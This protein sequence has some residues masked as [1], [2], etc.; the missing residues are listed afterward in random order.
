MSAKRPHIVVVGSLNVDHT[1]R[2]PHLPM[3]GETLTASSAFTCFGGKGANQALAAARA[4]AE[5][6]LVGAVG[7]DDYGARYLEHLQ[8]E[9]IDT[10]CLRVST[11]PTGAAFIAVDDRGE[12]TILVHPGANH[13]LLPEHLM[14]HA[15][16][17]READALLLQLECPL[18][19]VQQAVAQARVA[20][21]RVV[22]NPSPWSKAFLEAGMEVD[23][24]IVNETEAGHLLGQD[25]ERALQQTEVALMRARCQT[26]VI[27]RGARSTLALSAVEGLVEVDAMSVIPIDTVGAGDSFAGALVVAL[28]EGQPLRQAICFANVAGALATQQPGAQPAIPQRAQILSLLP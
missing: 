22:L 8:Q 5:V 6:V 12:N 4:G 10:R 11:I 21:V 26:L 27:T 14:S 7:P 16:I 25:W 2:V 18:A 17:I 19:T 20:G 13:D 1:L 28:S 15:A 23:V 24:L 9:G 3:P